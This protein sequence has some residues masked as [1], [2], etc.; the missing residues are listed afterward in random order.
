MKHVNDFEEYN[1]II[2]IPTTIIA[3]DFYN[4]FIKAEDTIKLC[5]NNGEFKEIKSTFDN[6]VRVIIT[7]YHIASKCLGSIIEFTHGDLLNKY[8]LFIDE[9]HLILQDPA[10]LEMIHEFNYVGLITETP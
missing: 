8:R 7:T 4:T 10:F 9:T 6:S 1:Y 3:T 5:I 2:V